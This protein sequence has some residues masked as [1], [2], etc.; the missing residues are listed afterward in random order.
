[1]EQY[2]KEFPLAYNHATVP[3]PRDGLAPQPVVSIVDRFVCRECPFKTTSRDVMRKHANKA[4]DK[5]RVAD[6][7]IYKVVRLQSWFGEKRERY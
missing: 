3:L 7:A 4:Y 6:E 1:V 5:K 2:V